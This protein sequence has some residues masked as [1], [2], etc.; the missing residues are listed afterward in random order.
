MT[1]KQCTLYN[2][3]I[4]TRHPFRGWGCQLRNAE[5]AIGIHR[6][7]KRAGETDKATNAAKAQLIYVLNLFSVVCCR[8]VPLCQPLGL[9]LPH[10]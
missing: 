7:T 5:N 10:I 9:L 1:V 6:S 2:N 3:S 4:S 8:V